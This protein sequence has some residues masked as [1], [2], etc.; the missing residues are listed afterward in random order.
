M[1]L[2][3]TRQRLGVSVILAASVFLADCGSTT[4][5]NEPIRANSQRTF[6]TPEDAMAAM[7]AAARADDM[8]GIKALFGAENME[9]LAT[10]DPAADKLMRLEFCAAADELTDLEPIGEDAMEMIVGMNRWPAPVPI[11]REDGRWYFD[12]EAGIDEILSRRIGR[13]ELEAISLCRSYLD[14]QYIYRNRDWDEDGVHEYAD[15]IA[16]SPGRFDG[17]YWPYHESGEMPLCPLDGLIMEN[18]AYVEGREVG[19]PWFG[20]YVKVLSR[21]GPG[22]PG[23]AMEYVDAGNMTAGFALIAW[24]A[25]HQN[26]GVMTFQVSHHGTVYE[27]DLGSDS[28]KLAA[29]IDVFDP[30]DGWRPVE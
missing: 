26:T 20:Y 12:S 16:S 25:K 18:E 11:V 6:A 15:R 24:P 27:K 28:A 4:D 1:G 29:G 23:G 13:N 3:L 7:I 2:G 30:S 10:G 22:A 21:Q 17:L 19:S 9:L 14:A 5:R 8:A